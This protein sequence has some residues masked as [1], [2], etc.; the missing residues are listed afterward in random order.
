VD[1]V[2]CGASPK[3][4]YFEYSLRSQARALLDFI[5]AKELTD[6]T[7]VGHSMGGGIALLVALSLQQAGRPL[8]GLIV[9]D[10][11]SYAQTLPLFIKL[12]RTPLIGRLVLRLPVDLQVRYVLNMAYYDRTKITSTTIADYAAPLRAPAAR[13]ALLATARHLIPNDIEALAEQFGTISA[14]TLVIWG[15]HDAVVPLSNGLRLHSA[16]T[17]STMTIID[18][19]GHV[20]PEEMPAR[21]LETMSE[22]FLRVSPYDVDAIAVEQNTLAALPKP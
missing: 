13:S 8:R 20:S 14:P 18:D 6:L 12:L 11:I 10:S 2:G 15:R 16:I 5:E 19:C 22:F 7:L 17:G 9:I 3:P 21:T 1:L 4:R